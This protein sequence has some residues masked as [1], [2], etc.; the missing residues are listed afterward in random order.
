MSEAVAKPA[1]A[2]RG[3]ERAWFEAA[4][5]ERLLIQRCGACDAAV[6]FPRSVCPVCHDDALE[7]VD[8][9]GIGTVYSYTV[10]HRAGKP[11][12]EADVPYVVALIELEEGPRMMGNL[13]NVEPA[14][15][16]IGMPVRVIF[17]RR[18]DSLTVPQWV[19]A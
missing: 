2:P 7:W 14:A 19:P 15:V 5:E 9:A 12:W 17:E 13:L 8:A 6:F 16:H 1:P 4:A 18:D 11:G 10:L 3:E